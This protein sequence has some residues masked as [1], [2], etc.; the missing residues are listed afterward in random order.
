M[1][2]FFILLL[3]YRWVRS[4]VDEAV[5]SCISKISSGNEFVFWNYKDIE[6]HQESNNPIKPFKTM[7]NF[8]FTIS[9]LVLGSLMTFF[10][11]TLIYHY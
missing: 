4:V 7:L 8:A 3:T 10:R 6:Y 2:I 11:L 9:I 1:K 5:N